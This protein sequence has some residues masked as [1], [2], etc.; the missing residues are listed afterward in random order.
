[1]K[2]RGRVSLAKRFR[3]DNRPDDGGACCHSKS[4]AILNL[5]S[6]TLKELTIHTHVADLP[7]SFLFANKGDK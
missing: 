1:M 4:Q 7:Q 5:S 6:E 3:L 2:Q